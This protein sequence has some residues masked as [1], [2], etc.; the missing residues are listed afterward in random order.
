[1]SALKAFADRSGPQGN[2]EDLD[3]GSVRDQVPFKA[4]HVRH[5]GVENRVVA[6]T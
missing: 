2:T 4:H 5:V 6:M 3:V 1:M